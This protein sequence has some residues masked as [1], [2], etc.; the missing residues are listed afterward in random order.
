MKK[1]KYQMSAFEN[2]PIN[3]ALSFMMQ[4]K[5]LA[6]IIPCKTRI[7]W[8]HQMGGIGC[9]HR[10]LE[11]VLV[12][13]REKRR[14]FFAEGEKRRLL[15]VDHLYNYFIDRKD[16]G[17]CNLDER[18]IDFMNNLFDEYNLPFEIAIEDQKDSYEAWVWVKIKPQ[19]NWEEI[20]NWFG[21]KAVLIWDNT[22]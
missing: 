1:Q 2:Y 12:P 15:M 6:L 21:E 8:G 4:E 22:D 3:N 17:G 13:F 9:L 5:N 7:F 14:D 19:E 18:A 10:D 11:G 20:S 16:L